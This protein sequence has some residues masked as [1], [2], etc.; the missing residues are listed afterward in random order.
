MGED[1]VLSVSETDMSKLF[2]KR[3]IDYLPLEKLLEAGDLKDEENGY[4]SWKVRR[5]V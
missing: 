1:D 2:N 3:L 4:T 5:G